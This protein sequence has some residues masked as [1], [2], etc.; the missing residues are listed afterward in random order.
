MTNTARLTLLTRLGFAARGV[1]YLI[2]ALLVLGQGRAEDPAGALQWLASGQGRILLYAMAV[3]LAAYG[4]WRL[5][6]AL[7]DIERDGTD[8]K[9]IAKRVGGVASGAI[10]L[11]LAWQAVR[12]IRGAGRTAESSADGARTALALPGGEWL[13]LLFGLALMVAGAYQLVKAVRGDYLERLDPAVATTAWARYT[14]AAGH[15]A[16][17]VVFLVSG[18]FF[19]RAGWAAR[20]SEAGGMAEALAWLTTPWDVAVALG[21]AAFG[22]YSF[23]EA[24]WRV[25]KDVP[26][27]GAARRVAGVARG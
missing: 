16:R 18:F 17:G 4:L 5:L 8:A 6:G 15:G 3:G 2:V 11:L 1:L 19:T 20:A 21:L 23:I 26:V 9:G 22:L 25:L 24:R 27:E 7:T 13:L 14:G 10:H 12:L